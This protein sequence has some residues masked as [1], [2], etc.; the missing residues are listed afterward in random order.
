MIVRMSGPMLDDLLSDVVGA[1]ISEICIVD[2]N[3]G[4]ISPDGTEKI[5]NKY[6]VN[7][8]HSGWDDDF[9]RVRNMAFDNL[10]TD[11]LIWLDHDDRI[12]IQTQQVLKSLLGSNIL[13]SASGVFMPYR[14]FNN[15]QFQMSYPRE[16]ILRKSLFDNGEIRWTGNVHECFALD[17]TAIKI[18]APIDHKP[19]NRKFIDPGRNLRILEKIYKDDKDGIQPRELFYLS[20]EYYWNGKYNKAIELFERWLKMNPIDWER[21]S[22]TL[23]LA[24]CYKHIGDD[25]KHVITLLELVA[26]MPERAEAWLELGLSFYNKKEHRKAIPFFIAATTATKPEIGFVNESSYSELPF[27]YLATSLSWSGNH[28]EAK[29][30]TEQKLLPKNPNDERL[31]Q[32][33]AFY[34]KMLV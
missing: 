19:D 12:P 8:L 33:M 6:N 14:M 32:N 5:C 22:G 7:L 3:P 18:D 10:H 21:Y 20:R 11:W 24:D 4:G 15:D 23:E 30:I 16:R 29:R 17:H 13:D 1:G 9:S 25:Q 31:L 34:D 2:T 26:N 28:V 27:D